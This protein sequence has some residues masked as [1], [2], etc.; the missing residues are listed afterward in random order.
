VSY[1]KNKFLT[2]NWLQSWLTNDYNWPTTSW[3]HRLT[4]D[5]LQLMATCWLT[6]N[7]LQMAA[8]WLTKIWP[9]MTTYRLTDY[10]LAKIW[11]TLQIDY[12]SS[13]MTWKI[14]TKINYKVATNWLKVDWL[15]VGSKW[16]HNDHKLIDFYWLQM[17]T[18]WLT[19]NDNKF[20]LSSPAIIQL[21]TTLI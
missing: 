21:E 17:T 10:N 18:S 15:Q 13:W 5:W 19:K 4:V 20:W 6:T 1:C 12:K 2:A 11:L 14:T 7:W 8:N 9:Q 3:P 16:P